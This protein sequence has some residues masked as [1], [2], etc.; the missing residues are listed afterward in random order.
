MS[1]VILRS[2]TILTM[3]DGL[4]IETGDV[5]SRDGIL[6]QVGGTYTPQTADYS[7]LDAEGCI[8]MPGLVQSHI[9]MCQTLARGRAD[10][11]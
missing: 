11:L 1:E 10:N 9:H 8:V 6:V 4:S 7:I 3:D 5:A 2:G